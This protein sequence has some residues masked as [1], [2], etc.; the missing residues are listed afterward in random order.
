MCFMVELCVGGLICAVF[1]YG[2]CVDTKRM[3][4]ILVCNNTNLSDSNHDDS[5]K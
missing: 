1:I 5:L 3:K 4:N 2:Y